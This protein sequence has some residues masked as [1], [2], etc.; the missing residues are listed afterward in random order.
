MEDPKIIAERIITNVEKVIIGKQQ[1]V[2][3]VIVALLSQGH[4]LIEDVPGVGKTRSE[5]RL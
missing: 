4:V 3:L 2:R 1:E 5:E